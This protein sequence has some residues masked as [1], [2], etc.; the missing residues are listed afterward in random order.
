MKLFFVGWV[1]SVRLYSF[2]LLIAA[3]GF[4]SGAFSSQTQPLAKTNNGF[5]LLRINKEKLTATL[6]TLEPLG[7]ASRRLGVFPIATGKNLGDKTRQGDN[8]TPEGIYFTKARIDGSILESKYGPAAVPLDYPNAIDQKDLKTGSGIWLHGTGPDRAVADKNITRGCVA[9]ED[10]H[11]EFLGDWFR[12]E[13]TVVVV[14]SGV[15]PKKEKQ[16][17]FYLTARAL[18][19]ASAWERRDHAEYSRF[20]ASS[21]NHEK[22]QLKQFLAHKKRIFNL[23]KEMH[24]SLKR[25]RVVVH[26]KYA[27]SVFEQHFKG[28]DVIDSKGIKVL[29]WQKVGSEWSIARE[30]FR[31]VDWVPT[32]IPSVSGLMALMSKAEKE[33]P[34]H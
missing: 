30:V 5:L 4:S 23:Y 12:P 13:S 19:W 3:L 1:R 21:F 7:T 34:G 25:L 27:I 18:S 17:R 2:I 26:K 22:G 14:D 33:K 11:I 32:S 24:V 15:M 28:D 10:K 6:N 8:K 9:F 20:Y 29:Y 31:E 16:S